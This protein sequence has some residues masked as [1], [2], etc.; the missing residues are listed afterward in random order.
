MSASKKQMAD[1][2]KKQVMKDCRRFDKKI[3]NNI[4]YSN[5]N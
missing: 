5:F 2:F 4:L 3:I 1:E